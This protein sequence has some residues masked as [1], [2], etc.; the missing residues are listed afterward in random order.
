MHNTS[1]IY[2]DSKYNRTEVTANENN[3]IINNKVQTRMITYNNM[4]D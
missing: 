1:I 2:V 4:F 3:Q